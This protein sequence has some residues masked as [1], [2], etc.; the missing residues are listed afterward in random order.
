MFVENID[1]RKQLGVENMKESL[2]NEGVDGV[3]IEESGI[4]FVLLG[5]NTQVIPTTANF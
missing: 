1:F 4:V 3:N 5:P 2:D